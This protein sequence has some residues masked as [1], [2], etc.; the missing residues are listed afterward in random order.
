MLTCVTHLKSRLPNLYLKNCHR[1]KGDQ[2]LNGE[3][4]AIMCILKWSKTLFINPDQIKGEPISSD[5]L[6]LFKM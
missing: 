6:P 1:S 3:R 5:S 2:K 4:L